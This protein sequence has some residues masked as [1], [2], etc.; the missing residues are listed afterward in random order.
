MGLGEKTSRWSG[1]LI[2]SPALSVLDASS[3]LV[4]Y[5]KRIDFAARG[6]IGAGR[7]TRRE[8]TILTNPQVWQRDFVGPRSQFFKPES[9]DV[10]FGSAASQGNRPL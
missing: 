2:G 9:D 10:I 6:Q 7:R 8:E 3:S 5:P 1:T 4:D